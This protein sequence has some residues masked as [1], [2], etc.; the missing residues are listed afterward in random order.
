MKVDQLIDPMF[1]KYR[2]AAGWAAHYELVVRIVAN[3]TP[4]LASCSMDYNLKSVEAKVRT[5]FAAHLNDRDNQLFDHVSKARNKLLH[6]E[7]PTALKELENL[8]H[9]TGK[10]HVLQ[11]ELPDQITPASILAAIAGATVMTGRAADDNIFGW[12]IHLNEDGALDHA[13]SVFQEAV[14]LVGRLAG[15][16]QPE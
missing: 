3:K 10:S 13:A 6:A 15:V 9:L 14:A 7:L 12:V 4:A 2:A 11:G 1:A 5:Y 8:G 16:R